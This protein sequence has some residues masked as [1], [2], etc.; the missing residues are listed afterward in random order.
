MISGDYFVW[1]FGEREEGIR[2]RQKGFSK[3][4]KMNGRKRRRGENPYP[5]RR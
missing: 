1:Y 2:N 5:I 3:T 4:R